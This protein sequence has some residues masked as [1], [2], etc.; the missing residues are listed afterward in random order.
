MA[1]C[2]VCFKT[3]FA[4]ISIKRL[5]IT[6]MNNWIGE[7]FIAIEEIISSTVIFTRGC[8][9]DKGPEAGV[10]PNKVIKANSSL[11][12]RLVFATDQLNHKPQ[13]RMM[14][15]YRDYRQ[16]QFSLTQERQALWHVQVLFPVRG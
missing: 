4:E 16:K 1:L 6:R 10:N 2:T 14:E 5:G 7:A 11:N 3:G 12:G 13:I 15:N 8:N 9:R